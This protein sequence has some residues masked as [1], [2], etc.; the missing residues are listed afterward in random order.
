MVLGFTGYKVA[1]LEESFRPT[2]HGSNGGPNVT[3]P[4]VK[5][6]KLPWDKSVK[7]WNWLASR[8]KQRF[9]QPRISGRLVSL[10]VEEGYE[11]KKGDLIGTIDDEAI[12]LQMQQIEANIIGIKAN[13]NQAGLTR[14]D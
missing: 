12:L 1:E 8:R 6:W 14:R 11:V 9:R 5:T 3:V 10:T 2:K 4:L 7:H 13:L